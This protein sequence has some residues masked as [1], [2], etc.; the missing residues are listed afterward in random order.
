MNTTTDTTRAI[1]HYMT[2][3]GQRAR[4]ASRIVG[5]AETRMKDAALLAIADALEAAEAQLPRLIN[6]IW[7]PV[8]PP[9]WKRRCWIGWN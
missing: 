8:A 2:G 5:R 6:G 3:V 1:G 7:M 4:A 9:D